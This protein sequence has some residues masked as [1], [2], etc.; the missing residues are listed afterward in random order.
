MSEISTLDFSHKEVV[1]ALLKSS[2]IHEGVWTLAV[3]LGL[4]AAN[5]QL[6]GTNDISPC[7]IVSILSLRIE[8]TTEINAL[9]VDASVVNPS[10]KKLTR[11]P[12]P[13]KPAQA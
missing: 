11:K 4:T 6:H 3:K 5:I 8:K 1:T 10:P 9:S 7:G 13:V 12:L 2:N